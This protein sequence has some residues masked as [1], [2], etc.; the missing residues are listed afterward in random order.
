MNTLPF[1]PVVLTHITKDNTL[2]HG[3]CKSRITKSITT[4]NLSHLTAVPVQLLLKSNE[5]TQDEIN[6]IKYVAGLSTNPDETK[7]GE[8]YGNGNGYGNSIGYGVGDGYGYGYGEGYE[9]GDEYKDGYGE[10]CGNGD[11]NGYGYGYIN[12]NQIH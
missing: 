3:V 4:H 10:G 7:Y 6:R 12:D 8:G 1:P 11:G 5:L 2:F 9:I